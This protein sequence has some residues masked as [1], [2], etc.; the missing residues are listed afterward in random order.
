LQTFLEQDLS[1][2]GISHLY[3]YAKEDLEG[4]YEKLGYTVEETSVLGK[5]L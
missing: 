3:I 4:F 1:K 2:K 5:R